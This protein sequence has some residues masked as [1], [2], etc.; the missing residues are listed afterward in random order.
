MHTTVD[1]WA[2]ANVY[3]DDANFP[4]GFALRDTLYSSNNIRV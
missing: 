1:D 2:G 3:V 4:V